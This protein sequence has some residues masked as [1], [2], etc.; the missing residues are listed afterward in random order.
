V[1]ACLFDEVAGVGGMNHFRLPNSDSGIDHLSSLGIHAMELLINALMK[2]GANR[3]RLKAKIFG[4]SS[5][6]ANV[7]RQSDIGERNIQF[8]EEFLRT[9]GIPIV[10]KFTG[11]DV[12]MQ[13]Y[14]H[15]GTTKALVKLLDP[16]TS[17][18]VDQD[19]REIRRES[20]TPSVT[21]F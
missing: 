15:T 7:N 14:F 5:V 10:G 2:A 12:G 11:G 16:S 19:E 17:V 20:E 9:E 21:L 18:R 8:A 13:V 3:N 4:G 6:L 1:A